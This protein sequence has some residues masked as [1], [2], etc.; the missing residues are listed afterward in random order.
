MLRADSVT[1][2]DVHMAIASDDSDGVRSIPIIAGIEVQDGNLH[3][4][5][6]RP[7]ALKASPRHIDHDSTRAGQKRRR[8]LERIFDAVGQLFDALLYFRRDRRRSHFHVQFLDPDVEAG[9]LTSLA[10][11]I[12][13][14]LARGLVGNILERHE[15]ARLHFHQ[16]GLPVG[17]IDRLKVAG[18]QVQLLQH[19]V[20]HDRDQFGG[21]GGGV[22]RAECGQLRLAGRP[23]VSALHKIKLHGIILLRCY[24]GGQRPPPG[25]VRR[26]CARSNR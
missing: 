15:A 24:G 9:L 8:R 5:P 23:G 26:S 20:A 22:R 16:R 12:L 10:R 4:G 13:D 14:H 2:R 11:V 21:E 17:R 3:T 19:V 1:L 25:M 18:V 6:V 7:G